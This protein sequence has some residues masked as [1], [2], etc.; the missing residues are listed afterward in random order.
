MDISEGF[1]GI[2]HDFFLDH[3]LLSCGFYSSLCIFISSFLSCGS[4]ITLV[5]SHCFPTFINSSV[6][7][8]FVWLS[9]VLLLFINDVLSQSFVLSILT[10]MTPPCILFAGRPTQQKFNKTDNAKERRSCDFSGVSKLAME[11]VALFSASKTHFLYLF[12][13]HNLPDN[14]PMQKCLTIPLLNIQ[15]IFR[16]SITNSLRSLS[17]IKQLAWSK[18]SLFLLPVL[19]LLQA[20]FSIQQLYPATYGAQLTLLF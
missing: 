20:A 7:L 6:L 8:A 3:K 5:D 19:S 17:F 13:R 1:G 4:F 18:W 12:T 15:H 14:P 16:L 2:W 11:N 10:L 9:S